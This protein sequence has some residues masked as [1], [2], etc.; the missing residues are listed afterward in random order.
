M[1]HTLGK[2]EVLLI[3]PV[4]YFEVTASCMTTVS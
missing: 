3:K 2:S 4:I 1:A